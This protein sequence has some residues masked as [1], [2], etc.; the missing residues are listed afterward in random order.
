VNPMAYLVRP[1]LRPLITVLDAAGRLHKKISL[2]SRSLRGK[3]KR[4]NTDKRAN[5]WH[6]KPVVLHRALFVRLEHLGD[7]ILALPTFESFKKSHPHCEVHVLCRPLTAPLVAH[8]PYVDHVLTYEP[9]WF[10]RSTHASRKSTSHLIKEVQAKRYDLVFEMHGDPRS[11]YLCSRFNAYTVGY[12]CRGG[13]FWLDELRH[14][15]P[16]K[17]M[18]DQNLDLVKPY[19]VRGKTTKK[20]SVCTDARSRREAAAIMRAHHLKAK[21]FILLK[22][23]TGRKEKDLTSEDIARIVAAVRSAHLLA[24]IVV[25]GSADEE[26]DCTAIAKHHELIN[27][28]GKTSILGLA[29]LVEKAQ[30]II[31]PDTWTVHLAHAFHTPYVPIYKTTDEH[32]WGYPQ[33][34]E[35]IKSTSE[36]VMRFKKRRR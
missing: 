15:D 19:L 21:Q 25:V 8:A 28:A 2:G 12:A 18:I 33:S 32:V 7:M 34:V 14:Y 30:L 36:L 6:P 17:S 3:N 35:R 23:Q 26:H 4:A 5:T 16:K 29:A 22:P 9:S 20:P 10:L 24:P 27:L 1:F 11:N 13:G 31:T